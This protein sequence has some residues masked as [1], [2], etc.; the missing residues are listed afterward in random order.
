MSEMKRMRNIWFFVGWVLLLIGFIEMAAGVYDLFFPSD[1]N[2]SLA[3]LHTDI[4]WGLLTVVSGVVFLLTN[5][6]K[7]VDL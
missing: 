3:Y 6:N 1:A 2:I 5:W 4:W 7:Y